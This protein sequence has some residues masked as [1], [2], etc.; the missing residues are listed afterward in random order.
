MMRRPVT[1]HSL[2]SHTLT[3]LAPVAI[4]FQNDPAP[5][6]HNGSTE[7]EAVQFPL[8]WILRNA[9]A[10]IQYRAIIDVAGLS[11]DREAFRRL[12]LAF[13]PALKVAI[14]QRGDGLW[15]DS[16][17]QVPDGNGSHAAVGTIPAFR[18]L[19]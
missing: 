18:R 19:L 16:I 2:F 13:P 10:A 4:P 12:P 1:T 6:G 3:Q 8:G 17:L 7:S 14:T 5:N 11:Q 15:G 9:S